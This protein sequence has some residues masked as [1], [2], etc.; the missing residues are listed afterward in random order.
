MAISGQFNIEA[1]DVKVGPGIF[2]R[3]SNHLSIDLLLFCFLE[4]AAN[5]KPSGFID[6]G[7]Q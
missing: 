5:L 6:A 3:N 2:R 7:E 1:M 4:K